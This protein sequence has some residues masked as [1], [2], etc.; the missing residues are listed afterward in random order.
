MRVEIDETL[1]PLFEQAVELYREWNSRINVISRKDTDSIWEHHFL[2]SLSID[3]YLRFESGASVLDL[4]TG[5]GF[6]GVPL[7]ILRPDV[8]FTLCDS[9]GKK[10]LV[11]RSVCDALGLSNVTTAN[12]RVEKLPGEWDYV[13]TRAVAS[14]SELYPWIRGRYRRGLLCLKGGDVAAEISEF[15]RRCHVAPSLIH[16]WPIS[17]VYD[18]EYFREKFVIHIEKA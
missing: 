17:N 2:H 7:A 3:R 15:V 18:D 9:I 8:N 11:A 16:V 13:V 6:P 1:R 12:S 4:G 10:I 14:L 5:G